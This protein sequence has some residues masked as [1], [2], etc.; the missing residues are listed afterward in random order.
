METKQQKLP[1]QAMSVLI[2]YDPTLYRNNVTDFHMVFSGKVKKCFINT[3]PGPL[4]WVCKVIP[5][6][7]VVFFQEKLT[8]GHNLTAGNRL[9]GMFVETTPPNA[10]VID[11]WFT[12][13][14]L[15]ATAVNP[16]AGSAPSYPSRRIKPEL[17]PI[18]VTFGGCPTPICPAGGATRAQITQMIQK[19][20]Q[21]I[22]DTRAVVMAELNRIQTT[23][24]TSATGLHLAT[25]R[26]NKTRFLQI[27]NKSLSQ[28]LRGFTIDCP[29]ACP[30]GVLARV[31]TFA[32]TVRPNTPIQICPA[33]CTRPSKSDLLHEIT[34]F[35]GSSD[36]VSV[37]AGAWDDPLNAYQLETI[38]PGLSQ[39][40]CRK[41]AYY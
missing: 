3:P 21:E 29:T 30:A 33:F 2:P 36:N 8:Y 24:P 18:T 31:N 11:S 22:S 23:G 14:D 13:A 5:P 12:E 26:A 35:G 19:S 7:R 9:S 39:A 20:C 17:P 41:T 6:N 40:Y 1:F 37:T 15:S 4:G 27:L 25:A 38:I 16:P 32:G 28:C 10:T 34:H